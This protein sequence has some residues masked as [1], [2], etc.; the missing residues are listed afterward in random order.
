MMLHLRVWDPRIIPNKPRTKYSTTGNSNTK[1]DAA[2]AS[3]RS[4]NYGSPNNTI[5]NNNKQHEHRCGSTNDNIDVQTGAKLK[6]IKI[7]NIN[8]QSIKNKV[9]DLHALL[10]AEKPDILIATETWLKEDVKTCELFPSNYT[11]YR[12][13][14]PDGYD[15]VL[16]AVRLIL[17]AS[18]RSRRG[19]CGENNPLY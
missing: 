11:F 8:F 19:R 13:D 7:L 1:G 17:P 14:R 5:K 3:V 6:L 10:D 2:Y 15:G 18:C 4:Q 16:I 12:K 9:A